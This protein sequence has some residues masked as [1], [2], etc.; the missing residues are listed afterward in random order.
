[1]G[2]DGAEGLLELRQ[3]GGRTFAQ[4]K[5]SSTVFGM[6]AEADRIGGAEKVVSAADLPR[7]L[8]LVAY[9]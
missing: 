6:P 4:D 5:A 7:Q 2:K 1:M 9:S 3:A 8:S